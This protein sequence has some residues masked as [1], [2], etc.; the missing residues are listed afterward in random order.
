LVCEGI[1]E[2]AVGSDVVGILLEEE[3]RVLGVAAHLPGMLVVVA[4]DAID[5]MDGKE[6]VAAL[7]G[8]AG[9]LDRREHVGHARTMVAAVGSVL[10]HGPP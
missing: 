6:L 8:Q 5:A 9:L 2:F 1:R 4:A 7:D 10:G 3:R